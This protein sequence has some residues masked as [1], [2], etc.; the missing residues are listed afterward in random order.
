MPRPN[1]PTPIGTSSDITLDKLMAIDFAKTI[2]IAATSS[3][4][5]DGSAS[6]VVLALRDDGSIWQ[7]SYGLGRWSWSKLPP[8]PAREP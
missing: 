5:D 2:Q 6:R 7:C 4:R 1:R 8:I 3:D